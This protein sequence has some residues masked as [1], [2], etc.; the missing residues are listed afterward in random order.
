MARKGRSKRVT[1]AGDKRGQAT[2]SASRRGLPM[3]LVALLIVAGALAATA[4]LARPS[5]AT[6]QGCTS[7]AHTGLGVGQCAPNFTLTD[8]HNRRVSLAAQRGHPVLIHFWGVPC[9]TCRA[10]YPDFSRAVAQF[11]PKG[12]RVLD[13]ESW[14][15]PAPMILQWQQTHHLPATLLPDV[16][17]EVPQL[18]G[19]SGT[20]T[21][22]FVDKRGRITASYAA[23]L[24]Y[25]DYAANIS[26]IM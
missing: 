7:S 8:L 20:P 4:I 25:A 15:S 9:T 12:L 22:F 26:H 5:T 13:V 16:S 18:Y 11:V 23:P 17:A 6:A 3:I 19:V 21:T 24:S 14:S 10:E 1:R 2:P